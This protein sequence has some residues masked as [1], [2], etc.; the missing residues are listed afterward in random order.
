MTQ[1]LFHQFQRSYFPDPRSYDFPEWV[2]I[3]EY[4]YHAADVVDLREEGFGAY[5]R[6]VGRPYQRAISRHFDARE[7]SR[8][9]RLLER[10][11]AWRRKR[12]DTRNEHPGEEGARR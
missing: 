10:F 5:A 2:L 3:G 4:F 8:T 9:E 6:R 11:S 1:N 12:L 7:L